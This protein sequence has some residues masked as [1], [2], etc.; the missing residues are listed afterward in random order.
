[1]ANSFIFKWK[2]NCDC[3]NYDLTKAGAARI[4]TVIKFSKEYKDDMHFDLEEALAGNPELTIDCHR[5]CVSTYTS[6][7]HFSRQKKRQSS[8]I[9]RTI[10]AKF[11]CLNFKC[12]IQNF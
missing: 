12:I 9:W 4:V 11:H 6:K 1:M 10:P 8:A 3:R 2:F 5:S 7:L